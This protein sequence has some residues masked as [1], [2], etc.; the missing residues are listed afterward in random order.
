MPS[1]LRLLLAVVG[2]LA[3][4]IVVATLGNIVVR[5]LLPG[6]TAVETSMA[7][8][9]PMLVSRL[10]V[11]ATASL[12]AGAAGTAVARHAR[13]VVFLLSAVLLILFV[14]VHAGLWSRFPLWYH[15]AFLGSL[16]PLVALGARLGAARGVRAP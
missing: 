9:L 1:W 2:G 15:L 14:P 6:Y 13:P 12:A 3:A 16:V 8:T 7:F 4:W 10:G 11:G 5:W